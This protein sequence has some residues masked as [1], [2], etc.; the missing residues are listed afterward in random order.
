MTSAVEEEGVGR[1]D[2]T[3]DD[4]RLREAK[5]TVSHSRLT[6]FEECAYRWYLE[7]VDEV[8]KGQVW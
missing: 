7:Y 4:E 1:A 8:P 2:P 3:S 6:R 5:S